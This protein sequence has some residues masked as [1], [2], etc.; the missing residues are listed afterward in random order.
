MLPIPIGDVTR[1]RTFPFVTVTLIAL[2][3]LVF[4]YEAS[5]PGRGFETFTRAYGNIPFEMI[6]GTDLPPRGP[7]PIYLTLLTS[8]FMHGSFL[9]LGGNMLYLWVFGDNVED[10]MGH[11]KYL[12]FYLIC[13]LAASF[14]H[15]FF[16]LD[17]R[18]PA[19]GA[20]GAISGILGAYLV[21]HP[22]GQVRTLWIFFI[23]VRIIY[24][25]AW[26][27]LGAYFVLQ[28]AQVVMGGAESGIAV[29]AHI[30]GFVAGAILI[31]LFRGRGGYAGSDSFGRF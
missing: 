13:G 27:L 18:I 14:T 6:T 28:F 9:H 17:S 2:N 20:S 12:I 4:L 19:V 1:S 7:V 8:I 10:S 3:V 30:G 23:V 29:W 25:P 31:F 15:I 22:H 11:I 24:L 21:L 5:L 26:I 16:N